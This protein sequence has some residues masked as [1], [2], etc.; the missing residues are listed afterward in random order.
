MPYYYQNHSSNTTRHLDNLNIIYLINND[1][2]HPSS[3]YNFLNKLLIGPIVHKIFWTKQNI[4]IQ[5]VRTHTGFT[6]NKI[7]SEVANKRA[8]KDKENHVL[9]NH[10]A[11]SMPYIHYRPHMIAPSTIYTFLLTTSMG[12]KK[13]THLNTNSHMK[14]NGSPMNT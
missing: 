14:K 8:T 4:T 3:L 9:H 10:V 13:P 11:H 2:R 1:I 6:S 5:K 7:A 12:N